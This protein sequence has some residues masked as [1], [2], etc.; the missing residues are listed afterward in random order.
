MTKDDQA[1]NGIIK[2]LREYAED[3]G[4]IMRSTSDLGPLEIWLLMKVYKR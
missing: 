3:T 1:I 2:I 4:T